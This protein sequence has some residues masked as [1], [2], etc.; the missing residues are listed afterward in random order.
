[1]IKPLSLTGEYDLIWSGDP[2]L[3][4]PDKAAS[5][6]EQEAWADRFRIATETGQWDPLLKPGQKPTRFRM[7]QI[8]GKAREAVRDLLAT[9]EET[10]NQTL[11][12]LFRAHLVSIDDFG[13]H[14]VR[15][16]ADERLGMKI[17][18]EETIKAL[19]SVDRDRPA[20]GEA[21]VRELGMAVIARFNGVSPL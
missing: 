15:R 13:D 17:A 20:I 12:Y 19:H 6:A 2:A 5:D 8:Y 1:M 7:C 21:I 18:T 9:V 3:D 14:K 4:A 16:A 11:S 10:P